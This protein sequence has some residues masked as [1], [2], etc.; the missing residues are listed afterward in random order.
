MQPQAQTINPELNYY[1]QGV[2]TNFIWRAQTGVRVNVGTSTGTDESRY[3]LLD[4]R[5]PATYAVARDASTKPAAALKIPWETR[6]N[7]SVAY[8]IPKVDLLVSTVFQSLPG[9]SINA[10][11]QSVPASAAIW[12]PESASRA[13]EPCAAGTA[14]ATV[15]CFGAQR[16]QATANVQMLLDNEMIGERTTV[17]DVKVAKNIR[18]AN[19]RAVI[20]VD[21][22]N[23]F[24]SDAIQSYNQTYTLDDPATPAVEVNNWLNPMSVVSP[25]FA[26]LSVQF[27][28]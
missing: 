11:L 27:S 10:Q 15:G 26:R 8:N 23:V 19:K 13:T 20:G 24:N 25:R 22:Y 2:D 12:Q 16:N 6:I 4:P 5:R 14:G 21:I 1:W 7:G 17:W 18:F 28:F 3:L 9:A